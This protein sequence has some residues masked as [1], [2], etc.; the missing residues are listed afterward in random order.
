MIE[1]H[2]QEG[3]SE[4][5]RG[6]TCAI[7]AFCRDLLMLAIKMSVDIEVI[8]S[9]ILPNLNPGAANLKRLIPSISIDA[10]GDVRRVMHHQLGW[11][12][13]Y[14]YD[15]NTAAVEKRH[16][17]ASLELISNLFNKGAHH[18]GG[19][20]AICRLIT[21]KIT[22]ERAVPAWV[23]DVVDANKWDRVSRGWS[24]AFEK[25]EF[26]AQFVYKTQ[27]SSSSSSL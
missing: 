18:A 14:V 6:S 22:S 9:D 26:E 13:I 12:E 24:P 15:M 3:E 25:N 2:W 27:S 11:D 19:A 17:N 7:L 5:R 20:E 1:G 4:L 10:G 16:I 21:L 8:M 23:T